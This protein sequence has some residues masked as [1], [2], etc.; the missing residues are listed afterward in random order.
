MKKKYPYEMHFQYKVWQLQNYL[1][2]M[3]AKN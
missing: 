2:N 1:R 3:E